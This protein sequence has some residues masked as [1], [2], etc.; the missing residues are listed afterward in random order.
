MTGKS[1]GRAL[2][3]AL[4]VV[5]CVS[6]VEPELL[7]NWGGSSVSL[8]VDQD[9]GRLTYQCGVGTIEPGWSLSTDGDFSA[10]GVH[11]FGGGPVPAE[12]RPPH[13]A[14]YSG[15]VRSNEFTLSVS[16]VDP[17]MSL[18]PFKLVRDGPE[19]TEICY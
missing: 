15:R 18:G 11:Y 9:G 10:T 5:A 1:A 6:P 8:V 19:V 14:Q 17:P 3:C 12:G 4:A 16:L 7:G 2:A 13:A